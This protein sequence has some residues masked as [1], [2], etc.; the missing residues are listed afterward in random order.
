MK[1][2]VGISNWIVDINLSTGSVTSFQVSEKIRQ[3]YLGGKGLGLELLNARMDPG[4]DPLG[5]KNVLAFIMSAFTGTD[6]LC[7]DGFSVVTKSP[8]TGLMLHS[9]CRGPF[10]LA[11]KTTGYDGVLVRGK[12]PG[13][14]VIVL[15]PNHVRIEDGSLNWGLD[16][17]DAQQ[18]IA[19]DGK[20]GVLA[21]GPAGENQVRIANAASGDCFFGRGGLGAAMGAKNLKAIVARGGDYGIVPADPK[22]FAKIRHKARTFFS[23]AMVVT[24]ESFVSDFMTPDLFTTF[25]AQ[26]NRLGLDGVS[27]SAVLRWCRRAEE[28]GL[29]DTSINISSTRG[30]TSILEDMAYRRG[31]GDVMGGGVLGLAMQYGGEEFAFQ[32]KGLEMTRRDFRKTWGQGLAYAVANGGDCHVADAM[33]ALEVERGVLPPILPVPRP[34]G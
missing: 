5:E 8:L 34:V 4:I 32:V 31:F 17:H 33:V 15:D 19:P 26:C 25:N 7:S 10:G 28:N 29:I 14:V 12:A 22:R 1:P 13:P 24:D 23:K 21:I 16:I 20:A 2:I 27:A 3:L 30:I 9:A 18:Q 6:A 11:C